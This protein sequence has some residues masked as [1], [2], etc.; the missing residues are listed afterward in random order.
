M[1]RPF[2]ERHIGINDDAERVMLDAVGYASR[3]ELMQ[4]AVPR[5]IAVEGFRSAADTLLPEPITE[6]EA[7][8]KS[9]ADLAR[10]LAD[11]GRKSRPSL[12]V[13]FI[14]GFAENAILGGGQLA[15]GTEVLTKPFEMSTMAN[16]VRELLD[17]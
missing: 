14:T 15:R 17:R 4:A 16:T 6:A 3:E 9:H 13:L 7:L 1:A 2:V 11:A 5:S 10:R 8:D 12:K